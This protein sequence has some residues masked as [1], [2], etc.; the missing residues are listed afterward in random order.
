MSTYADHGIDVPAG[1]SGEIRTT[2][3]ECSSDRKKHY[4]K[5]LAVNLDKGTWHCHHCGYS[6]GLEKRDHEEAPIFTE[7]NHVHCD[8]TDEMIKYFS[9]RGISK[10][11]LIANGVCTGRM[12]DHSLKKW[13]QAIKF[14]YFKDGICVNA[15]YKT[16]DKKFSQEKGGESCL[17]RFDAISGNEVPEIVICEGEIDALAC[18]EAGV[19]NA[20]SVPN[21]A[22]APNAKNYEKE[23]SYL[24]SAEAIFDRCT[25]VILAV[26][27][28]VP[29]KKLEAELVRRIGVEKC[30][31]VQWPIGCKDAND[32]LVKYDKSKLNECINKAQPYPINGIYSSG[33][34]RDLVLQIYD[35]GLERGISTGWPIFDKCYTIKTGQVT[36]VTGIPG[37]GKS[38]FVDALAVHLAKYNGWRFAMFS[39]ENWPIEIHIQHLVE[40]LIGKS[41]THPDYKMS[42]VELEVN[43]DAIADFFKFIVPQEDIISVDSVLE[44]VRASIFR[45]GVKGVVLD[46]WNEFEHLYQNETETQYISR[47]LG[48]IRR[49]AR[50]HDVH[51]WIIAH[52]QKL[53][54]DKETG[55]YKPPTMYEISG[56]ANW[57][58]KADMGLCVFRP[59]LDRDETDVFVQ[60]VRFR[61]CG[62]PGCV[63]FSY[64]RFTG[65]FCDIM[66]IGTES[67]VADAKN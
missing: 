24:Q 65:E 29:G 33:D 36:I 2:C 35:M 66:Q 1:S 67:S 19:I 53:S 60:K 13:R 15:K 64:N 59:N 27:N 18:H 10:E 40:R 41:F 48:K 17:Y 9:K 34:V 31:R 20:T 52:P 50:K 63:R 37:H 26:D 57:R 23:F 8:L 7:V 47:M 45:H 4:D 16:P 3:P 28:D 62:R 25:R 42:R 12:F 55:K 49:F 51:I 61:E 43:I 54:K 21:G 6:G 39:P 11:I 44:L 5:C 22:P 32:V 56:G 58:N 14:P 30:Y 46:P 38:A